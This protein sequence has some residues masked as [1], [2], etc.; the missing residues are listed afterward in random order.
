[1]NQ[2]V[3]ILY[4]DDEQI[5]L[6]LFKMNFRRDFNIITA[7]DGQEAL[8]I[9]HTNNDIKIVISDMKMPGMTGVELIQKAKIDYPD[10]YYFILTGYDIT[11][12][13]AEALEN[14]SILKCFRKP[15]NLVEIKDSINVALKINPSG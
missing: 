15:F 11:K 12:E 9:L 8:N 14:K 3:T 10:I 6:M 2:P 4:I 7:E 1:M 13:I 5:N